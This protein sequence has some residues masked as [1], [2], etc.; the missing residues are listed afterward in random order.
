MKVVFH[1]EALEEMLESARYYDERSLGLGWDF[2]MPSNRQTGESQRFQKQRRFF[3]AGCESAW[4][5]GFPSACCTQ[6]SRT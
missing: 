5:R 2:F 3:E 4:C 1:L 6:L